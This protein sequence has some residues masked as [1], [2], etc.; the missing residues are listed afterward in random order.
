MFIQGQFEKFIEEDEDFNYKIEEIIMEDDDKIK[1]NRSKIYKVMNEL[2][3]KEKEV[4]MNDKSYVEDFVKNI[5]KKL[6]RS[7]SSYK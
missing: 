4:I 7:R 6:K 5:K 1:I 2:D 3:P